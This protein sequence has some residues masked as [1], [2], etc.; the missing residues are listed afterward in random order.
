MYISSFFCIVFTNGLTILQFREFCVYAREVR[1][2][3]GTQRIEECIRV[4]NGIT[5]WVIC[6][7]LREYTMTKRSG[8]IEKFID[9]TKVPYNFH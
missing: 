3:D 5:C 9:T 8:T 7:I 6:N 1:L 4:F 2:S